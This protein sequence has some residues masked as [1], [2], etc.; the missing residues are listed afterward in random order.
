MFAK[1]T[2][3]TMVVVRVEVH[4]TNRGTGSETTRKNIMKERIPREVVRHLTKHST[5][6]AVQNT[7]IQ[8]LHRTSDEKEN[9]PVS[10]NLLTNSS[11]NAETG[12]KMPP[13]CARGVRL[14]MLSKFGSW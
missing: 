4:D 9:F 2:S 14:E 10:S 6:L 1:K 5:V 3:L 7:N 11:P 13:R 12:V 8:F